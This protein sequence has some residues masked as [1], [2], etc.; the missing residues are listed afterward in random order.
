MR[1]NTVQM[2]SLDRIV[3]KG[4]REVL[5][6]DLGV[7]VY[8]KIEKEIFDTHGITVLEAVADFAKLD[9]VLRKFFGKHTT[10]IESKIFRKILSVDD[11]NTKTES[12]ITIKDPSVAKAI[13]E[14]YGDPAKKIILDL[15]NRP[16]SI[17]EAIA[18]SKLPKASAYNRIKEMI[19]DGLLTAAGHAKAADGR[20]VNEYVATFNKAVFEIQ[21]Q[22]MTVNVNMHN[23]FLKNSFTYNSIRDPIK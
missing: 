22:G 1:F 17:P 4:F 10:N 3:A 23:K 18:K 7:T 14:S 9:L 5:E 12:A 15:L 11:N 13:F 8:K 20:K 16:K 21:S 19:Q 6:R 2:N